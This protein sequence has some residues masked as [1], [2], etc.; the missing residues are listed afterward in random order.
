[1]PKANY[2]SVQTVDVSDFCYWWLILDFQMRLL[3]RVCWQDCKLIRI[4]RALLASRWT[5]L[6]A[7]FLV[8]R[9]QEPLQWKG[10]LQF[11]PVIQVEAGIL[12]VINATRI[13]N[14]RVV[15]AELIPNQAG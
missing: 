15:K 5:G 3:S 2:R 9:Y 6:A 8:P 7:R 13:R 11:T 12:F 10:S 1:M 14:P 4:P